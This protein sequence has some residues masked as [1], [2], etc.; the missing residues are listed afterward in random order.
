M[1]FDWTISFSD[2][3]LVGGGIVAFLKVMLW[4]RDQTR[5]IVRVLGAEHPPTGIM[6]DV[7]HLKRETRRHRDW[8]V[9]NGYHDDRD[10]A[11]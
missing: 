4:Q 8:L 3:V 9:A 2:V 10:D 5:D 6:G 11:A 7:F 1:N